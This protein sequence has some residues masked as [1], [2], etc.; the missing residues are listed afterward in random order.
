[1][2]EGFCRDSIRTHEIRNSEEFGLPGS[3][4]VEKS[5]EGSLLEHLLLLFYGISG[6][7]CL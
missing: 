5:C 6:H 3:F 7:L 1:M 4:E 2:G